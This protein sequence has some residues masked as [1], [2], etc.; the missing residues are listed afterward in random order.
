[1]PFGLQRCLVER[2]LD[3][4]RA[5]DQQGGLAASMISPSSLTSD[6]EIPRQEP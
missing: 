1:V 5:D 2:L 6:R 4:A 3:G